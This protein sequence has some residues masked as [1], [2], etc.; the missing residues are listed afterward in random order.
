MLILRFLNEE[1]ERH[2]HRE[3]EGETC[4]VILIKG[5]GRVCGLLDLQGKKVNSVNGREPKWSNACSTMVQMQS[6]EN[7]RER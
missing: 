7:T 1:R 3:R 6:D 5:L 2:T 4:E